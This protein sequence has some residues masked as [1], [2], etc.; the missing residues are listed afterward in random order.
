M[1]KSS[2]D[3]S[4]EDLQSPSERDDPSINT[5]ADGQP[6]SG[7]GCAMK[8]SPCLWL[9]IQFRISRSSPSRTLLERQLS[10]LERSRGSSDVR[11]RY[12]RSCD[13]ENAA[14][15]RRACSGIECCR[16]SSIPTRWVVTSFLVKCV[17]YRG[18]RILFGRNLTGRFF[19]LPRLN[20]EIF[21]A[22]N[23]GRVR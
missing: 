1:T 4:L 12:D 10:C 19:W 23:S 5:Q 7:S 17:A 15:R 9:T 2:L 22:I 18:D 11:L 13:V 16:M 3:D 8:A 20:L 14:N 6:V 21:L